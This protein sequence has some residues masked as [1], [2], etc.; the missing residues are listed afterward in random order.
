MQFTRR[1]QA[2][3]LVLNVIAAASLF[4]LY[5]RSASRIRYGLNIT[6][7]SLPAVQLAY[8]RAARASGEL[9]AHNTTQ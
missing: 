3:L 7:F 9:W 6:L 5:E 2:E 4:Y 1:N 8:L